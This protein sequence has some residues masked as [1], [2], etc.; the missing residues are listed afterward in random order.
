[1]DDTW[2]P[3]YDD[4][5]LPNPT[6]RHWFPDREMMKPEGR[7]GLILKKIRAQMAYAYQYAPLYRKKWKAA[8]LTPEDVQTIEDFHKVP[9]LTKQEIRQDQQ[10]HPPFGSYLCVAPVEIHRIHGTSGTT[11]KPTAYGIGR[12]DWRRIAN[13]HA[14]IMWGMGLR[15]EDTLFIG[16]FFSLYIGSWGALV[17]AERL[18][19]TSFPFGAGAPGQTAM[20]VRWIKD[21]APTTF[22]GTPSYALHLAEVARKE[23]IDPAR[24]FRFRL[25]FFSGE[26]GAGIPATKRQIEET[27]GGALCIDSG[28]MG[29]MTPW[30]T[31]AECELR[32]GMHLWQDIVFTELVH[33]E[34]HEVVP[35]GGEGVPVY[36]HL[37]RTSQP[38]IRYYSGDLATWTDEPCECGRT[39]P[40]LPRGIYGRVDD[41]F[42]V[43]G[44]NIYPSAIEEILRS[45]PGVGREYRI[46]ISRE[47]A[48]DKLVVQAEYAPQLA[49]EGPQGRGLLDRLQR[50]LEGRFRTIL[51]VRTAVQ[52]VEPDTLPRTEFK[53]R[54][55]IDNRDLFT[56]LRGGA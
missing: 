25:M 51:G 16:S 36:T 29:E 42:I 35:Y 56:E 30:M 18:G 15:P 17:G 44:E 52:L 28:S 13:A 53:A 26:P 21:L 23:G 34:T 14:R 54:R 49:G 5:Y 45:C 11:G 50:E 24:D 7:Q 6:D 9:L 47:Q 40:R 10:E 4:T 20:A 3:T 43:R 41:M 32:R 33:P 1:M 19:M 39:Y 37:E 8:G 31:N 22:Y 27:Y 48:M 2:P 46:V 12:E 55:V 38:M